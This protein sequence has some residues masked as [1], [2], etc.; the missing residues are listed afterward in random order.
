MPEDAVDAGAT[1]RNPAPSS[2]PH[3]AASLPQPSGLGVRRRATGDVCG[4]DIGDDEQ[5]VRAEPL[6]EQRGAQVLVDHRFDAAQVPA[7]FVNVLRSS[8]K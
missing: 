2:R 3:G 5:Q 8:T 1:L 6:S 4:I 7:L